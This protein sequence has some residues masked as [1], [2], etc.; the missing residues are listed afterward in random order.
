[1]GE[2][3]R[4][5]DIRIRHGVTGKNQTR[6]VGIMNGREELKKKKKEKE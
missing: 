2:Q 4:D 6:G 1:M 5:R 3:N